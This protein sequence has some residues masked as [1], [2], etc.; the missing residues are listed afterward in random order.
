ME[1]IKRVPRKQNFVSQMETNMRFFLFHR[2][3]ISFY[4]LYPWGQ[5]NQII[6]LDIFSHLKVA[7]KQI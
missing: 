6:S 3:C 4:S 1:A 2:G 7:I 5:R